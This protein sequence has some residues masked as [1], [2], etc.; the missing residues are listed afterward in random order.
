MKEN[1]ILENVRNVYYYL[2]FWLVVTVIY[3]VLLYL[4]TN[5]SLSIILIDS[6]TANLL[7]AGF[8]LSFWYSVKYTTIDE[9]SILKLLLGHITT[10]VISTAIWLTLEYSIVVA[11]TSNSPEYKIF[12]SS[13]LPWRVLMGLLFYFMVTSYYYVFIFYSNYQ[14]TVLQETELKN[15]ITQAELKSLK[16]QIN[17][18]FIFNSLNSMSA[19]AEIEPP[20]AKMM[21]IKLADFLRYSLATNEKQ[22]NKLGEEVENIHRYLQIEKIRFEEKFY[23]EEEIDENVFDIPVPAMI[24]QPLFENAIKHA[25]YEAIERVK[26]RLCCKLDR[27]FL[28]I[29]VENNFDKSSHGLAKNGTGIGL[30]NISE[31]MALIY[32]R[33]DLMTIKKEN[34]NFRVDISIPIE[35]Q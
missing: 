34:D 20:K 14:K 25:V 24:L 1:P 13:S 19:L 23:F 9:N 35:Q 31:R 32:N 33:D 30:K 3:I 15:L 6:I 4:G 5:T 7:L 22:K 17:P 27:G 2:I 28:K 11:L 12:F 10:S 21:I 26:I 8:G 16:F 29:S 18:H